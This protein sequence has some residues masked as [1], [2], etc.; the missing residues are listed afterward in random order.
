[1]ETIVNPLIF[2]TREVIIR[3]GDHAKLFFVLARGS[4]SVQIKIPTQTGEKRRRVASIGSGLTFGEMALFGGGAPARP[5][6]SP[7]RRSSA[8]GSRS[9]SSRSSPVCVPTS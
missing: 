3:E 6:S 9:S 5:T 8:M 7:T 4:V 2:E 1:M